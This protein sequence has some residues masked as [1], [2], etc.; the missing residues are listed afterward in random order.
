MRTLT[1]GILAGLAALALIAAGCAADD[2]DGDGSGADGDTDTDTDTDTDADGDGDADGDAD[3]D[4]S[5]GGCTKIDLLFVV[6]DS[7]SMQEEQTNLGNNFP[8]FIGVLEEYLTPA[9]TQVE[10]RVGVTTTGVTRSFTQNI[11]MFPNPVPMSSSG[12]DGELQGID[13]C[14]LGEYPWLDG[15]GGAANASTFSC[16]AN[17]GT[18]GSGTEMPFAAMHQALLEDPDNAADVPAQSAA[19]NPN[20]GFYRKDEA[21]LLVVVFITDEDDC[22]IVEGGT[23][24]VSFQG[25][26]DCDE[27]TSTGLYQP[28][29]MIEFLDELTGGGEGRY[30]LV[31]IAGDPETNGCDAS[32]LGSA[33]GAKRLKELIDM[34]GGWGVFGDICSGDLSD[35]LQQALDVI[36]LACDEF[37]LE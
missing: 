2:R 8:E 36:E 32:N 10:Y 22:S 1:I 37:P 14:D 24:N 5:F 35:S 18:T 29:T 17:Q 19:G 33:A 31:G 12:P 23:M 16:M 30:V 20:E 26:S 15:P 27:E 6:D 7:G 3:T 21:S 25:G 28:E 9:N 11:P 34:V 13:T 4:P